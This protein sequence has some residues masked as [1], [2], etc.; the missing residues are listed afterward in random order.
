M[1]EKLGVDPFVGALGEGDEVA[2][3]VV[4]VSLVEVDG[5][6]WIVRLALAGVGV[7]AHFDGVVQVGNGLI[8]FVLGVAGAAIAVG[9]GN[10]EVELRVERGFLFEIGEGGGPIAH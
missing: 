3:F 7:G 9:V 6:E 2:G 4:L 10:A 8:G 1:G 5:E